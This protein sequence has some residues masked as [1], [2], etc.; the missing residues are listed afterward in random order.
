MNNLNQTKTNTFSAKI[1]DVL[2]H[3]M[4]N[5]MIGIGYQ[6]RLFEI[7]AELPP[8]TSK[9]IAATAKLKERYVR[10]W[11]AAMAAGEIIDYDP[12]TGTFN[13]PS[14]HA[15]VLTQVAGTN[16]MARLAMV[17]PYLASVQQSVT[18][19]FREGGGVNYS[20]YPDFMRLWSEINAERFDATINQLMLPLMPEVVRALE[21]GID[22]LDV[23]CGDGH[24]LHL[25]AKAFP[26]S[27]FTGYDFL[28]DNIE[29]AR[30][31]ARAL[32]LTNTSFTARDVT[33]FIGS[34]KYAF[35]TAFD[36]IHDMAKPAE[37][38]QSI[39]DSL[40]PDGTFLLV[41]LSASSN[42]HENLDHPLGQWLY[43]TSC[44]HCMP[45]SLALDGAGLGTMWG[46]QQAMQMLNTAGFV[47]I[48]V[49]K[50]PEDIFN[51][52]YETSA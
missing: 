22:V 15:S 33:D 4:L 45:V 6:T 46:E 43:T 7:M 24:V 3:A 12:A 20:A 5:L 14:E 50:I 8:S 11:L 1:L 17:V 49:K 42:L 13:L 27:H 16:N 21:Q 52:Y 35:I 44:M 29:L 38:L 41:D 32:G 37:V 2:N 40:K 10:E 26:K 30:E 25:M 31:R 34:D 9:Q 18:H 19:C 47:N 48:D 28:E 23:G 51:N 39:A 36:V